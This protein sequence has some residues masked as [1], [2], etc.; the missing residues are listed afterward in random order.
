MNL[1]IFTRT[2]A[3]NP[4]SYKMH[5]SRLVSKRGLVVPGAPSVQIAETEDESATACVMYSLF[6]NMVFMKI[7]LERITQ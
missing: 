6:L 7:T 1:S 2:Y 4:D 3:G 5:A